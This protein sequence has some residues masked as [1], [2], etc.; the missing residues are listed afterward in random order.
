M[1]AAKIEM[2]NLRIEST[3]SSEHPAQ[4]MV[5]FV[6]QLFGEVPERVKCFNA[7]KR[8]APATA[9]CGTGRQPCNK[10]IDQVRREPGSKSK[11]RMRP[12]LHAL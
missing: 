1:V 6:R 8:C 10:H 12:Q 4:L 2:V 7:C 11:I 3:P 5:T 9:D